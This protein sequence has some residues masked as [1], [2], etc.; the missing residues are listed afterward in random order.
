MFI[1]PKIFHIMTTY[2]HEKAS[3]DIIS[4]TYSAKRNAFK[5]LHIKG[6]KITCWIKARF[7]YFASI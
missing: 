2:A 7:P 5:E 6:L 4:S 3:P 1:N